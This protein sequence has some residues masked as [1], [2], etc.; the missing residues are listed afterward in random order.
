M[1]IRDRTAARPVKISRL[2]QVKTACAGKK[3]AAA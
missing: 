3:V 1:R 2:M